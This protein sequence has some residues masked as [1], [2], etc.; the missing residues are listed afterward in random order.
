MGIIPNYSHNITETQLKIKKISQFLVKVFRIARRTQ[1]TNINRW[2]LNNLIHLT[3]T[4]FQFINQDHKVL[5][6]TKVK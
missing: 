1:V 3:V 2:E 5:M 4:V 6:Q